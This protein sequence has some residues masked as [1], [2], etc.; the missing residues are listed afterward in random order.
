MKAHA[1]SAASVPGEKGSV[2]S[3]VVEQL[4]S[5]YKSTDRA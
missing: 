5:N 1:R 2:A 4:T 3:E